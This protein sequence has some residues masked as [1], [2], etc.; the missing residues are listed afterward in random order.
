MVSGGTAIG[1][2]TSGCAHRGG[3]KSQFCGHDIHGSG[4]WKAICAR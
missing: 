2:T 3:K 1:K 4:Y